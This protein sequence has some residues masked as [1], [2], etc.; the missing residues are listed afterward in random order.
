LVQWARSVAWK[1]NQTFE[2]DEGAVFNHAHWR[3]RRKGVLFLTTLRPPID[4]VISS[5]VFDENQAGKQRSPHEFVAHCHY[6]NTAR[7]RRKY[8]KKLHKRWGWIWACASDCY[9]KWFGSWPTRNFIANVEKAAETLNS[10]EVIWM[11]NLDN[12]QYMDWLL[13]RMNATDIPIVHK[14][15]TSLSKPNFT[16]DQLQML[17]FVNRRDIALYDKVKSKWEHLIGNNITLT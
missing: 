8:N 3:K 4:R 13:Y 10:Y 12:V 6:L 17:D 9:S 1:H 7:K 16:D 15:K 11:K 5:Y 14:R 2:H